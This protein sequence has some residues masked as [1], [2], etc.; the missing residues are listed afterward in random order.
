MENRVHKDE[1]NE[2]EETNESFDIYPKDLET[3][4]I[5]FKRRSS[6]QKSRV[7]LVPKS[8]SIKKEFEVHQKPKLT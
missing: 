6:T 3:L 8:Q 5:I 4:N 2:K 7:A 1:V